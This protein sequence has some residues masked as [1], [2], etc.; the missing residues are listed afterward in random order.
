MLKKLYFSS[1]IVLIALSAC[2]KEDDQLHNL[3][4]VPVSFK[5]S[6]FEGVKTRVVG[7][8][9]ESGDKIGVFAIEN[10]RTLKEETIIENYD[11][12]SFS[13]TGNGVF[14]HNDQA[15]YY[16]EDGSTI[17][18][19]SYYPYQS[20]LNAY[21]YKI[22]ITEQVDL[23]YSNNL[24]NSDKNN[25]ENNLDFHRV[26]SKVV[27]NIE[28]TESGSLEGLTVEVNGVK[29]EA[30]FSLA[31]G[32]LTIETES[33]GKLLFTPLGSD[34]NKS[35]TFLLLPTTEE[36]SVEVV[37]K[38]GDKVT[39]K[40]TIPHALQGESLYSYNINLNGISSEVLPATS[41]MELPYYTKG[42]SAPNSLKALH[43]VGSTSW[44]NGYS[45]S[46]TMRNYTIMFDTE[47][48]VPYWIAYPMHSIFMRSGNRTNDWDFD[49]I[50][51][52][53]Y[54][55]N[56]VNSGWTNK[57]Y[58][59][60]HML[61]SADRSATRDL[62]RTTFYATNMAVQDVKMNSGVWNDLEQDLRSWVE[63]S[64]YDTIYVVTGVILPP[65]G[66][67]EYT[68][69]VDG[70][71]VAIPKYMY[72]ALLKQEKSSKKWHSIAFN[73][74]NITSGTSY[75]KNVVSVAELED[76]TGFTFFPNLGDATEVKSQTSLSHW[77]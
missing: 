19:I 41:Y 52:K 34:V 64:R 4:G 75:D 6:V 16:P 63:D 68:T 61:A 71:E 27:L 72:K 28:P 47:N 26:L 25:A 42:G 74:K 9:W 14:T 33:T 37:F 55:P 69:D 49:P 35:V 32:E 46:N 8:N 36:N 66:Q 23:M 29:T 57:K 60:G 13:T 21:N 18:F 56:I 2:N 70:K 7:V 53:K 67:I 20:S 76:L 31:T 38:L 15:I 58:N 65:K 51:P 45:G 24:K 77:R 62:N 54:Q 3:Q 30:A 1:L 50:I 40:W 59:R 48:S 11:N 12:L 10:G 44:L 39:Y 73:M 22:D 17:D 5:T 43:M